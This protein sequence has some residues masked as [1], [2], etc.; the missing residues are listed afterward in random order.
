MRVRSVVGVLED[1]EEQ[2]WATFR[3]AINLAT[4]DNARLTLA[5]T[6]A[7]GRAYH[8]VAPFALFDAYFP[9]APNFEEDAL[10]MLARAVEFVPAWLPIT[11]MVLRPDTKNAVRAL[12][13][14][15][16]YDVVVGGARLLTSGSLSRE[17]RKAG[18]RTVMSS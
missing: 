8:L 4:E 16:S 13:R 14:D 11:T 5:K 10:R 15:G 17:I 2:L 12:I 7:Y 1:D 18:I 6:T 9:P 3:D